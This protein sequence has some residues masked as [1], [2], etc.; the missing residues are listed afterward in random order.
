VRFAAIILCGFLAALAP[1]LAGAQSARI[2]TLVDAV[3]SARIK[4]DVAALSALKTRFALSPDFFHATELVQK[5]LRASGLKPSLDP[6]VVGGKQV[7]NVIVDIQGSVPGRPVILTSAHYDSITFDGPRAPGAEDNASGTAGLLELA[8][9]LAN[10]GLATPVRLIFFAAE[11]LGLQGSKY[12]LEQYMAS[13]EIWQ[14]AALINM[15]MI[16]H[17]PDGDRAMLVDTFPAS[18]ALAGRIQAAAS[19]FTDL[20]V[21]VDIRATGRSDHRPFAQA[22]VPAVNL[23]SNNW[24]TYL[25]YHSS[26]DTAQNVDPAMVAEVT[27]A[28]LATILRLAGFEDG[29]PVAHGGGHTETVVG[30]LISLDGRGSFDPQDRALTYAWR[31]LGGPPARLTGST[32]SPSFFADEPGAY[33]FELKVTSEDG[34]VS[35]PDLVGAVVKETGGCAV[36]GAGGSA[37]W[38]VVVL[39]LWIRPWRAALAAAPRRRDARPGRPG[40][41]CPGARK[42]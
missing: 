10:E 21:Y 27:R 35:E 28:N 34:R 17:D 37:W 14:L 20:L 36:A 23:A 5:R 15:D 25:D 18:R 30:D 12:R 8:H 40:Q 26:R 7:N 13:G 11:E 2:K 39:F 29:P 22:G 38:L 1:G 6:F 19:M 3:S 32:G 33:R 31:Q 42:R 24:R 9:L 4:A 16:G 41:A